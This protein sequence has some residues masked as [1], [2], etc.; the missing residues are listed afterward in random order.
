MHIFHLYTL[1]FGFEFCREFCM[2]HDLC[3][4]CAILPICLVCVT[5]LLT[6]IY[7]FALN[8]RTVG[9][10]LFNGEIHMNRE[11]CMWSIRKVRLTQDKIITAC[12]GES[13]KAQTHVPNA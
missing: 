11:E 9:L 6:F 4:N 13:L 8:E 3:Y 10:I 12:L 2:L 7:M 5:I 1:A